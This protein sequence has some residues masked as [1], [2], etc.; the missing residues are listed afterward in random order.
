[1]RAIEALAYKIE[2]FPTLIE[3]IM[4]SLFFI[5]IYL[6]R[7]YLNSINLTLFLSSPIVLLHLFNTQFIYLSYEFFSFALVLYFFNN[8]KELHS[9]ASSFIFSLLDTSFSIAPML[10]FLYAYLKEKNSKYLV[11]SSLL[12]LFFLT[13]DITYSPP[14]YYISFLSFSLPYILTIN[15]FLFVFSFLLSVVPSSLFFFLYLSKNHLSSTKL[16]LSLLISSFFSLFFFP[17]YIVVALAIFAV[18]LYIKKDSK[19]LKYSSLIILLLLNLAALIR[20]D[21]I[22][23]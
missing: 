10:L 6:M 12:M 5:S 14:L 15:P 2:S 18:F 7:D 21:M 19:S 20:G 3:L 11:V 13:S 4:I 9:F 23:I 8:K 22:V 1:M 17:L 16:S